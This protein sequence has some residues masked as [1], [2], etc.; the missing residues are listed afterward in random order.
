MGPGN[1]GF[2][3]L[4]FLPIFFGLTIHYLY[5]KNDINIDKNRYA[6]L[7]SFC[8][9]IIN[10]NPRGSAPMNRRFAARSIRFLTHVHPR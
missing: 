2:F 9:L 3:P 1:Y 8:T 5:R 10:C 6:F 7:A 4:H